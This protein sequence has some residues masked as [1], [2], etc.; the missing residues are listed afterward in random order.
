MLTSHSAAISICFI[1]PAY[2]VQMYF[3]A[4]STMLFGAL[5]GWVRSSTFDAR[6]CSGHAQGWGVAAM[7]AALRARSQTLLAS[8]IEREQASVAGQSNPDVLYQRDL[9]RGVFL[10]PASSAVFGA[11]LAVGTFFAAYLKARAPKVRSRSPTSVSHH[12]PKHS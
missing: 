10:D 1:P 7:A 8:Q 4:V 12:S 9:F 3:L 5:L 6:S 2:P 11:F